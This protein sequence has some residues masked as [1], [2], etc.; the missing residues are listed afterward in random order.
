MQTRTSPLIDKANDVKQ[1]LT[2]L[3]SLAVDAA[4]ETA[5]QLKDG[6]TDI[7]E[8]GCAQAKNVQTQTENYIKKEPLKALLM[9]GAAGFAMGWLV[10]R[11]WN[12]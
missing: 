5:G 12:K 7:Y 10:T 11:R 1:D 6:A 8:Q 9:A 2:E 4:R 3:G